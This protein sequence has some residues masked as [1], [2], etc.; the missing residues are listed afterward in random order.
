MNSRAE[1]GLFPMQKMNGIREGF[2]KWY[3]RKRHIGC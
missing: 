2:W 3:S 1:A